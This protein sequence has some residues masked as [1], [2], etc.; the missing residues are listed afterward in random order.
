MNRK[1]AT[2]ISIVFHPIW[3][4]FGMLVLYLLANPIAFG[5]SQPFEDGVLVLQTLIICLILPLVSIL[6]MWKSKLISSLHLDQRMERIGPY[7]AMLIFLLWYYLNINQYGVAPVFRMYILGALIALILV[8]LTNLFIKVSAHG[9]GVAGILMN[10]IAAWKKFDYEVVPFRI[11]S[12]I[13]TL[14]F[15]IIIAIFALILFIVLLSRFYLKKH[16]LMELFGGVLYGIFGQIVAIRLI[17]I[18]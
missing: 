8:F 17:E 1:L 9:A 10:S 18:I 3:F 4:P 12:S 13:Y 16:N 11:L 5:Q 14:N 6:I 7:I 15:E 2:L